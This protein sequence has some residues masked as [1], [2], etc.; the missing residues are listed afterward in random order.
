M[1]VSTPI[2]VVIAVLAV[3]LLATSAL[4]VYKLRPGR[5][6]ELRKL[7]NVD[8]EPLSPVRRLTVMRGKVI[9]SPS[10]PRRS[11]FRGWPASLYS[12]RHDSVT[13]FPDLHTDEDVKSPA[14][15][16]TPGQLEAQVFE[17]ERKILYSIAERR[18]PDEERV[19][20]EVVIVSRPDVKAPPKLQERSKERTPDVPRD[21]P[22][23]DKE[24]PEPPKANGK[25]SRKAS[26]DAAVV[27]AASVTAK[28]KSAYSAKPTPT[29]SVKSRDDKGASP[30]EA[31]A[32][33]KASS[34]EAMPDLKSIETHRARLE[35]Q[36][37][38]ESSDASVRAKGAAITDS[39][40][41]DVAESPTSP[42][43]VSP[44]ATT[45]E[46]QPRA[47]SRS[48]SRSRS[49]SRSTRHRSRS[50][51]HR[52]RK[53][54]PPPIAVL[55]RKERTLPTVVKAAAPQEE[56]EREEEDIKDEGPETRATSVYSTLTE[57]AETKQNS[58]AEEQ[59]PSP[60]PFL[61]ATITNV[62]SSPFFFYSPTKNR[63]SVNTLATTDLSP[64]F[65]LASVR[66]VPLIP[67]NHKLHIQD[68][69]THNEPPRPSTQE[70]VPARKPI[71]S[72]LLTSNY[73]APP[74]QWPP[75]T[76]RRQSIQSQDYSLSLDPP[77]HQA[78]APTVQVPP[79]S[80][81]AS[82]Y[83]DIVRDTLNSANPFS[84]PPIES[85]APK[86]PPPPTA[87][88]SAPPPPRTAYADL[89]I[90]PRDRVI[91]IP[92][93]RRRSSRYSHLFES[94]ALPKLPSD[95]PTIVDADHSSD[96]D[97]QVATKLPLAPSTPTTLNRHVASAD[98]APSYS[99]DSKLWGAQNPTLDV[100]PI[101]TPDRRKS[102]DPRENSASALIR[103]IKDLV[104]VDVEERPAGDVSPLTD[105]FPCE[106]REVHGQR[107][108]N[109]IPAS[110][111]QG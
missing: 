32:D 24:L 73:T 50:R 3:G 66:R 8:S 4:L 59:P 55:P 86:P 33:K 67:G 20:K 19:N 76:T 48:R 105:E 75:R 91:S 81:E 45:G 16:I 18:T 11:L 51:T 68:V 37:P 72:I 101:A 38:H 44:R 28:P 62:I 42:A 84:N 87:H 80:A 85:T 41:Q 60:P 22:A 79:T 110:H 46:R 35:R 93:G 13:S 71:P 63:Q 88:F 90:R 15:A 74:N 106:V 97:N 89:N 10:S 52:V 100:S 29:S 36:Q 7:S 40:R 111:G 95:L 57:P 34:A 103:D 109:K 82:E 25:R 69:A 6:S 99:R 14:R 61:S 78:P 94:K 43:I 98:A 64:T 96:S 104:R 83:A 108:A 47:S 17:P 49:A 107:L 77:T 54:R 5:K 102:R 2:I 27:K 53:P 26:L 92:T 9:S 30:K 70:T 39:S 31:D 1:A 12:S 56:E 21:R 65:S 58:P 23:R